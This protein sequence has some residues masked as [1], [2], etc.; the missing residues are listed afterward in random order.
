M[1]KPLLI[2]FGVL[3]SI[4]AHAQDRVLTGRVTS[5]ED[6]LALPGV[7]VV[8]Q[9][10]AKGTVTDSDGKYQLRVG[11]SDEILV[12]S[13]IG[14]ARQEIAIGNRSQIDVVMEPD[15]QQLAEVVVVGYGTEERRLLA[16]SVGV[17]KAD[18]IKDLPVPN[19]NG[20][21]QGQTAGVQVVQNSGTPGAATSVRVRG[22]G[23]LS[24][25][26]QPLYIVDGIPVT[27]GDF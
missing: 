11:Q 23:S 18:A 2:L 9:G 10:T 6:G 14:M 12:F 8:V 15:A 1:R 19:V 21:L 7:S 3:L 13:F 22:S 4:C 26:G 27:T 25:S 5:S 16:Q 24:G 20:V 17:V